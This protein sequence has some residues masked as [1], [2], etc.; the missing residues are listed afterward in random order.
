M[1]WRRGKVQCGVASR[2]SGAGLR[3]LW[4]C[5]NGG[6]FNG[7]LWTETTPPCKGPRSVSS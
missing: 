7:E 2:R 4:M 3:G 1:A 6:L 5:R